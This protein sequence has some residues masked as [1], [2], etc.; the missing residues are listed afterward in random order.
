MSI[1]YLSALIELLL[2][3][4][5]ADTVAADTVAADTE[6]TGKPSVLACRECISLQ[7]FSFMSPAI[8]KNGY[9]ILVSFYLSYTNYN[10]Q[11]GKGGQYG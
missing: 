11:I 10:M 5:I 3:M 6:T 7:A 1:M 2:M 4:M 9:M 8:V